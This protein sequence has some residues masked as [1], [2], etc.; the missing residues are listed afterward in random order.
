MKRNTAREIAVRLCFMLSENPIQAS[1]LLEHVFEP[2]YYASL[3]L[4]DELFSELPGNQL[5][6]ISELIS[7]IGLHNAELDEYVM[8]YSTGWDF[9]RISRTA[10]AIIKVAMYEI[11]YMPDIPSRVSVNEAV[12]LAKHYEEDQTVPFINGLLGAFVKGEISQ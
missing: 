1:E 7:G 12:E 10:L 3:A 5:T 6:Y 2:E 11:L 9:D 8:R 4:E